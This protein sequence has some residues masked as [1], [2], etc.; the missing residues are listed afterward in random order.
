MTS[1]PAMLSDLRRLN[2]HI[3]LAGD[4]LQLDAPVGAITSGLRVRGV[5]WIAAGFRKGSDPQ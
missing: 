5:D 2:V 3:T 4:R 1:V